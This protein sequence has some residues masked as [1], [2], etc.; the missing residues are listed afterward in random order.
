MLTFDENLQLALDLVGIF[1]FALTGGPDRREEAARPLRRARARR[2]RGAG[3]RCDARP[4]DRPTPPVGISDWR[5][6]GRPR[7]PVSS[8]SST[9]VARISKVV[10]VLDAAGLATFAVGGSL[11]A[12]GAGWTRSPP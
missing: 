8:R 12:L 1:A 5:L 3:G 2:G 7:W 6:V 4:A 9:P 10:R 11:K